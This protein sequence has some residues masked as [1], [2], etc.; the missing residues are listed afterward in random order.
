M[1]EVGVEVQ[2]VVRWVVGVGKMCLISDGTKAGR[3]RTAV[4]VRQA[5][6]RL[7]INKGPPHGMPCHV[8]AL[9]SKHKHKRRRHD[10]GW[11]LACQGERD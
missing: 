5:A 8:E 7:L 2:V 1:V 10:Q 4:V 3:T 11:R 9:G 6:G